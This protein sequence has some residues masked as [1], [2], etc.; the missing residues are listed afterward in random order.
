MSPAATTAPAPECPELPRP[1]TVTAVL[2][3]VVL[4]GVLAA[5]IVLAV[6]IGAAGL[7]V[8][9]VLRVV[10]HHTVA[11]DLAASDVL[12]D[13]IVWGLR[14]P[15]VLL[16]AVVGAGL[17]MAG[18]TMQ[19]VVRNPLADPY[20]LGVSG[21]AGLFAAASITLGATAVAGLTT[22]AAAFVGALVAIG[23]VLALTRGGRMPDRIALVGVTLFYVFIGLTSFLIFQS[24]DPSAAQSVLFWLLGSLTRASWEVLVVPAT[25]TAAALIFLMAHARALDALTLGDDTAL[26]LGSS[27]RALRLRLLVG[28]SLLVGALVAATGAIGFVGLLVPHLVRLVVGPAHRALLPISAVVGAT[29]LVLVDLLCRVL[30][31]PAELPVGVVTSILGAPLLL[32]LLGRGTRA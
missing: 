5:S 26:A 20:V 17:A 9:T 28:T 22:S 8:A 23:L 31:S 13:Q 6:V 4:L 24:P 1:R 32:W 10:A 2:L 27:V 14:L 15:R 29:Y 30:V 21:G 18:A 16:A 11:A 3:P 19:A 7:D 25:L 12:A